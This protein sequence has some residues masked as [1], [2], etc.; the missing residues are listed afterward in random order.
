MNNSSH[1]PPL[2]DYAS[3][4][5]PVGVVLTAVV[6]VVLI[7][8]SAVFGWIIIPFLFAIFGRSRIIGALVSL[9]VSAMCVYWFPVHPVFCIIAL[10]ALLVFC[11][12]CLKGLTGQKFIFRYSP[13]EIKF[14]HY[15][16]ASFYLYCIVT[17]LNAMIFLSLIYFFVLHNQ[18][19]ID[20]VSLYSMNTVSHIIPV[21]LY[22]LQSHASNL[23][24]IAF[25]CLGI[26]GTVSYLILFYPRR[27]ES[28]LSHILIILNLAAAF[29]TFAGV[30]FVDSLYSICQPWMMHTEPVNVIVNQEAYAEFVASFNSSQLYVLL[31]ELSFPLLF[32]LLMGNIVLGIRRRK[33]RKSRER[34]FSLLLET[35][36][37]KELTEYNEEDFVSNIKSYYSLGGSREQ[38]HLIVLF[39]DTAGLSLKKNYWEKEDIGFLESKGKPEM[40]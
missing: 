10:F 17:W 24:S 2:K 27:K 12:L 21:S 30:A 38:I 35:I 28:T 18:G 22:L 4:L 7:F 5:K 39:L 8:V 16:K 15:K 33:D 13:L 1:K 40:W 19:V 14:V 3:L 20:L 11:I 26:W 32:G 29:V 9:F 36:R 23:M 6:G 25:L 31:Q 34:V 37:S